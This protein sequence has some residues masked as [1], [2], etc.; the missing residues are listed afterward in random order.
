MNAVVLAIVQQ[1]QKHAYTVTHPR[2]HEL[3]QT[4]HLC[5]KSARPGARTN[6]R[7]SA[8][9]A[10]EP[11]AMVCAKGL[12]MCARAHR[13]E[14]RTN[15]HDLKQ[16]QHTLYKAEMFM[17]TNPLTTLTRRLG[18]ISVRGG[19]V[20]GCYLCQ[21]GKAKRGQTHLIQVGVDEPGLSLAA[22]DGKLQVGLLGEESRQLP[23]SAL[24]D[25]LHRL[26][27]RLERAQ[28]HGL[29]QHRDAGGQ[30]NVLQQLWRR[31]APLLELHLP[32]TNAAPKIN[33]PLRPHPAVP[34][35]MAPCYLA[36]G[37]TFPPQGE[38]RNTQTKNG[39]LGCSSPLVA[40]TWPKDRSKHCLICRCSCCQDVYCLLARNRWKQVEYSLF[41]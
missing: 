18:R 9:N 21:S 38:T 6:K 22:G 40:N 29:A 1:L 37:L 30:F 15:L 19:G 27:R 23:H 4:G 10:R 25:A 8:V 39:L 36:L 26:Q 12:N 17:R 20:D 31:H 7:A 33:H 11:D 34:A 5:M 3:S 13:S 32:R 2:V 35:R 16:V 28:I 24:R 41:K 14:K